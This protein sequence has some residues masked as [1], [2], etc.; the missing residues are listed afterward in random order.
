V[1]EPR[2]SA[3]QHVAAF[4]HRFVHREVAD[5]EQEEDN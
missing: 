5:A 2:G 3:K 1:N 4:E